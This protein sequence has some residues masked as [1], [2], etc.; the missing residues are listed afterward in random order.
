MQAMACTSTG[1][2][3]LKRS[4]S[5]SMSFRPFS[6]SVLS[7]MSLLE[8]LRQHTDTSSWRNQR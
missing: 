6:S 8:S 2:R 5:R 7:L 1:F 3:T 4:I